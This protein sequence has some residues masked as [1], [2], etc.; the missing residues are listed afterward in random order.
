MRRRMLWF[1]FRYFN[2]RTPTK[3]CDNEVVTTVNSM[4]NFNPRTP[5]K[6]C[7]SKFIR[8]NIG[9][10]EFQSTHPHEGVRH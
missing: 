7:D 9:S 1:V 6:E 2:P 3:E 4:I 10:N 8:Y 5:T